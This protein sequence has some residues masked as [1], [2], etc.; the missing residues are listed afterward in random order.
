MNKFIS[1]VVVLV[2]FLSTTAF[3]NEDMID[4]DKFVKEYYKA[5]VKTQQPNASKEDLEHYLSFLTE[6][7]GYQHFPNAPDDSRESD[8]KKMMRKGMTHYLG[9]HTSYESKLIEY[10]V[11]YN[12]I[13]L[14]HSYSG[15][16]LRS[17]GSEFNYS[18]VAL[19]VLELENGKV[20]V[21][22]RYGK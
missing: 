16:G 19:D 18:K 2:T 17:D 14:K 12:S 4:Y 8:G 11:G 9:V 6:D 1:I 5:Q 22:R 10:I 7:I 15:K 3:A 20:S 21:I 13:A